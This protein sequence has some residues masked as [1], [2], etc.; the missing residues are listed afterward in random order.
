MEMCHGPAE[1]SVLISSCF[2]EG[3]GG[4]GGVG[5]EWKS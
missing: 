5:C 2:G 1:A 3:G 4:G